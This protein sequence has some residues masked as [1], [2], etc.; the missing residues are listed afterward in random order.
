MREVIKSIE[1]D[2]VGLKKLNSPQTME[3]FHFLRWIKKQKIKL[4]I[5]QLQK[6]EAEQMLIQNHKPYI[7]KKTSFFLKEAREAYDK[8]GEKLEWEVKRDNRTKTKRMRLLN[9]SDLE[10]AISVIRKN[11]EYGRLEEIASQRKKKILELLAQFE[12]IKT[13][14]D[15]EIGREEVSKKEHEIALNENDLEYGKKRQKISVEMGERVRA[16]FGFSQSEWNNYELKVKVWDYLDS[17]C[18]SGKYKE[19]RRKN[20]IL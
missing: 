11:V 1:S 2:F 3:I 19:F 10:K 5:L 18:K 7:A 12:G 4:G 9:K 17:L 16:F 20:E 15:N 8:F 13:E 6:E 14:W